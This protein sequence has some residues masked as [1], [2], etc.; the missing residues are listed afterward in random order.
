MSPGPLSRGHWHRLWSL[1]LSRDLGDTG[2][3]PCRGRWG[4]RSPFFTT[5]SPGAPQP[6]QRPI[7]T[8][9]APHPLYPPIPYISPYPIFPIPYSRHP[10]YPPFSARSR[11][12]TQWFLLAAAP[13]SP[14]RSAGPG[15]A[16]PP[17]RGA[18]PGRGGRA[19][20]GRSGGGGAMGNLF[21]RKRRSRVTE[22]DKAVLVSAAG[23]R[24]DGAAGAAGPG[25]VSAGAFPRGRCPRPPR[26]R[27]GGEA[28]AIVCL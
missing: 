20:R 22:Q 24:R 10:L 26:R 23:E 11:S 1:G 3:G 25:S 6:L 16:R 19:A 12:A 5:H 4:L 21:G 15:P 7:L 14:S 9:M 2:T 8:P 17:S 18:W 13:H 27:G 28:E